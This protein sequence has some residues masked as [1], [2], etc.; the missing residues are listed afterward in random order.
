MRSFET[1]SIKRP[2]YRVHRKSCLK[3][4]KRPD[5]FCHPVLYSGRDVTPK[6]LNPLSFKEGKERQ[7]SVL[8]VVGRGNVTQSSYSGSTFRIYS[9]TSFS[10]L[11][12]ELH[13]QSVL[14]LGGF[15][16]SF[17]ASTS[18]DYMTLE[19]ERGKST[20]SDIIGY[21]EEEVVEKP[22]E[23]PSKIKVTL[24]ETPTIFIFDIPSYT[25]YRDSEEGMY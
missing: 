4:S 20:I 24:V 12:T 19:P 13:L 21:E 22:L 15:Q 3:D 1:S 17:I 23:M 16:Q 10:K 5:R 8:N 6:P 11:Q 9:H 2:D 7:M 14:A 25:V 18:I